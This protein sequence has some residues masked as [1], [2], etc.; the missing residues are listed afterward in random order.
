[1]WEINHGVWQTLHSC[2]GNVEFIAVILSKSCSKKL[3]Q[4][5]WWMFI[6]TYTFGPTKQYRIKEAYWDLNCNCLG[7]WRK[8]VSWM[9]HNYP[10]WV[11]YMFLWR[12]RLSS[13]RSGYIGTS[14]LVILAVITQRHCKTSLALALVVI[15]DK[16]ND[17]NFPAFLGSAWG[18]W[19]VGSLPFFS[20]AISNTQELL[21]CAH[22]L[23][24]FSCY[25]SALW[26]MSIFSI[27]LWKFST[28]FW[29][30]LFKCRFCLCGPDQVEGIFEEMLIRVLW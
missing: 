14:V 7:L 26:L 9:L 19:N 4:K 13:H 28:S 1:M 8:I 27:R 15:G 17:W 3:F 5:L 22:L 30:S 29:I 10:P 11:L 25:I 21:I 2:G 20:E 16:S 18:C 12:T 24:F 23:S 6:F